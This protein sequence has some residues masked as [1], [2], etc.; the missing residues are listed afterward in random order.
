MPQLLLTDRIRMIDFIAQHQE[1]HLRQVLHAQQGV[2]LGFRFGQALVVFGVHEEDDP[3]YFGEIIFP[4]AAGCRDSTG[5]VSEVEKDLGVGE[6]R[7]GEGPGE[8]EEYTLLMAA[9]VEGCEAAVADGEFFGC[10]CWASSVYG[11]LVL[12][13]GGRAERT[14]VKG[15]L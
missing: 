11:W 9:E 15:G 8:G 12:G 5:L 13:R 2:E 7:D 3:A 1:R 4:E 14:W 6:E 10:C